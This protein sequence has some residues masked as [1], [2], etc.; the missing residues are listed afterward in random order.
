MKNWKKYLNPFLSIVMS[1]NIVAQTAA[2]IVAYAETGSDESLAVADEEV[3]PTLVT[4]TIELLE[5]I[6][7]L[8]VIEDVEITAVEEVEGVFV[9]SALNESDEEFFVVDIDGSLSLEVGETYASITGTV[10]EQNGAYFLVTESEEDVV[11]AE[12]PDSELVDEDEDTEVE[13][14]SEI[15]DEESVDETDAEEVEPVVEEAHE[16]E[17]ATFA[18]EEDLVPLAQ[19]NGNFE[20]SLMHMNDTHARVENYAPMYTAIQEYRGENPDALL[21]HAGDVFS[22]TLYFNQFEGMADLAALNRMGIDAMVFGNH[23]F[24]LGSPHTALANFVREANFPLLGTNIDFSAEPLLAE[25]VGDSSIRNSLVLD[26]DGEQVGVFGLLTED[27]TNI[28]SP[29]SVAFTNYIAA[30]E[31]AVA[32]FEAQGI[33][34]IIALTHLGFASSPAF[35]NDLILA[36]QVDGIDI[37]VGGHSHTRVSPPEVVDAGESPT[38]IVQAGANAERLG[39]LNVTFDENGDVIGHNGQLIDISEY[40]PNQDIV[41][42]ISSYVDEVNNISNQQIG[43]VAI[44]DIVNPRQ[45]EDSDTNS[46]RANETPLGNLVTDAMLAKT[47]E[48]YPETVIAFQ[49]GGG[50]RAPIAAGPITVGEVISVLPFGNNPVVLDLSGAELRELFEISYGANQRP[51]GG[52]EENGGFLHVSGMEIY[53]DSTRPAGERIVEMFVNIDG[54][55]V[56][57]VDTETYTVTTNAF[58]AQGGDGLTPL[59]TAYAAGRVQDTGA[60]DWEQLRDYMIEEQYLNRVVLP[61]REGRINDLRGQGIE[62]F[63]VTQLRNR[64]DAVQDA[65]MSLAKTY[66]VL[67]DEIEELQGQLAALKT[68]LEDRDADIDALLKAIQA[69]E[70]RIAALEAEVGAEPTPTPEPEPEEPEPALPTPA[71]GNGGSTDGTDGSGGTG[72][73]AGTPGAPGSTTTPP[74]STGGRT[75]QKD[76]PAAGSNMESTLYAGLTIIFAGGVLF[77]ISKRKERKKVS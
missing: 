65:L 17:I 2:P 44:R 11:V 45:N 18:V 50:I 61:M 74:T 42:A 22:G 5:L 68:A 51:A 59:A 75:Q 33:N 55:L 25:L 48:L 6:D 40:E 46:V 53:F 62:E 27:T 70:A 43:A 34:K 58:T 31:E 63:R 20:L 71:P 10:S 19:A 13:G 36:E 37:I 57:I 23:E 54:Q 30:A 1:V 29:G 66:P 8:A 38:V 35:G 7:E 16:A 14:G 24:D 76:L 52:L 67:L 56:P 21:L 15:E 41:N 60:I 69:L 47:K 39:T 32:A 28:A 9:Y 64:M 49:N 73:T 77:V 4:T 26:V 72:S 3:T 12:Q